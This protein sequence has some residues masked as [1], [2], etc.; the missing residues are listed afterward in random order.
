[1]PAAVG[2]FEKASAL[3]P[4]N[5]G[6]V[7]SLVH[8]LELSFDYDK[9][10]HVALKFFIKNRLMKVG[11]LTGKMIAQFLEDPESTDTVWTLAWIPTTDDQGYAVAYPVNNPATEYSPHP[12]ADEDWDSPSLDFMALVF[13][14]VKIL[15]F[16]GSLNRLPQLINMIEPTRQSSRQPLH[17][18]SI[19]NEHAYYSTIVQILAKRATVFPPEEVFV[20][21]SKGSS[22]KPIYVIGDSHVSPL[23]WGKIVVNGQQR[24][25]VP[26][27]VTG[28]K[29]WHLRPSSDFYPKANFQHAV[30]SCS[31]GSGPSSRLMI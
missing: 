30:S 14:V 16:K 18:T 29:H 5:V 1:M 13:T 15:Y 9:A 11:S 20:N 22:L 7:L 6:F 4:Q 10:V 25:L 2:L 28:I 17:M 24:Q 19:R 23:A 8:T 31:V 3:V 12:R 21:F 26:K 27:L